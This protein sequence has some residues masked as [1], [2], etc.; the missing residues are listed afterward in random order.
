MNTNIISQPAYQNLR[1]RVE[2]SV[3]RFL[4]KHNSSFRPTGNK[5]QLRNMLRKHILDA[6][7]LSAGIEGI[8]DQA[9]YPKIMSSIEPKVEEILYE[10]LGI[11]KPDSNDEEEAQNGGADSA[12]MSEK[13]SNIS[14]DVEM[15]SAPESEEQEEIPKKEGN[16]M[17]R[18]LFFYENC[19]KIGINKKSTILLSETS[20]LSIFK[21]KNWK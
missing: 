20:Q 18:L 5:T 4:S 17:F 6:S 11:D 13:L 16:K 1:Q 19:T 2:A 8:V 15:P 14:S 3:G 12:K 21:L 7:F 10:T 9:V